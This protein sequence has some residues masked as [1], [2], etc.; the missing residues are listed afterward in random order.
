MKKYILL[1][2]V[3]IILGVDAFAQSADMSLIP[4][5]SGDKWGFATANKE[6][7]IA[8]K[9]DAVDWFSEGFAAA[10][11]G[12]KWGYINKAGKMV[13]PVRYTVA[14]PFTR[15]FMPNKTD[16]GGDTILFAGASVKA[17]GYEI[18]INTKGTTLPQCPARSEDATEVAEITKKKTYSLPNNDGLFDEILSDYSYGGDTYYVAKKGNNFG[19]F[20]TKFETVVPFSYASIKAKDIGG[21]EY[22]VVE[23]NG[24]FGLLD[25]EGK[26]VIPVNFSSLDV[27]S[28]P[29]NKGYLIVT[30]NGRS[31]V[32]DMTGKNI[33]NR[34]FGSISYDTNGGFILTGD[35]NLKGF[36][37]L[38]DTYISPKYTNVD[39]LPGGKYL[40]VRTFSG[41]DGYINSKGEEFFVQ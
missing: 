33:T 29:M 14:K 34:G 22:M 26:E 7:V 39:L 25:A 18:C 6:I 40:K 11:V 2:I 41:D 21:K 30:E 15:G 4:Y 8:P 31:F 36:Y 10:Q 1:A 32:K 23:K 3:S 13:I 24:S 27:V 38:D 9:Y 35:N 17:D 28:G 12:T 16:D 19:V 20:N 5:R 37:F